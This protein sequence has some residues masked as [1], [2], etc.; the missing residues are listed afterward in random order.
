MAALAPPETEGRVYEVPEV[1]DY[2]K[3]DDGL[4][5]IGE[6]LIR[7]WPRQFGHLGAEEIWWGWRKNGGR[8]G[9]QDNRGDV[10]IVGDSSL[11]MHSLRHKIVVWLAADH[12]KGLN[13][14]EDQVEAQLFRN[15]MRIGKNA[16][17]TPVMRAPDFSGFRAELEQYGA[18]DDGLKKATN[19][20]LAMGFKDA[21][22]DP[23]QPP[24]STGEPAT[25]GRRRRS[26][27]GHNPDET[28]PE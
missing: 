15:L 25:G 7:R 22:E 13:F 14:T 28:P 9:R 21:E 6:T 11:L 17:G 8:K 26:Q 19:V 12:V 16:K 10:L 24:T 23:E 1:R 27:N 20:Q 18:W 2:W 5:E 3:E 4:K